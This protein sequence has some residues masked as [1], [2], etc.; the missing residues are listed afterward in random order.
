M[1]AFPRAGF[2][3]DDSYDEPTEGMELRDYFAAKALE[4]LVERVVNLNIAPD[5]VADDAYMIADAMMKA[6]AK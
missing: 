2:D 5:L 3:G 6:R 4:G 1:Q